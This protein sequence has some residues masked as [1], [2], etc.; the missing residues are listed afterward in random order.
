MC[1]DVSINIFSGRVPGD[2]LHVRW[3][4]LPVLLHRLLWRSRGSAVRQRQLLQVWHTHIHTKKRF[5]QYRNCS[6]STDVFIC[7]FTASPLFLTPSRCFCVDCLDILVD[8]GAS[9]NARHLDPWRCYMCQPLLQYGVL[10]QRHDWSLKLQEFFANDNGQEFVSFL[11]R[12]LYK[13]W[14]TCK[15]LGCS[16][17]LNKKSV[18]IYMCIC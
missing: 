8:P 2:V 6:F 17:Y 3:R 4:R 13:I 16:I 9:N 15:D 5:A 14:Q 10:K 11:K 18:H 12:L 1:D 7:P